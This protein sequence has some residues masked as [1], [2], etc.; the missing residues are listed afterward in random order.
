M[1][2]MDDT[3]HFLITY[4]HDARRQISME[5]FLDDE[6][7]VKAYG[8]RE[9]EFEDN[10]RIEVVLLGAD[11]EDAI[12]VTHANYFED[13]LALR[14]RDVMRTDVARVTDSAVLEDALAIMREKGYDQVPV[15]HSEDGTLVGVISARW[16]VEDD[17]STGPSAARKS[18]VRDVMRPTLKLP[19]GMV[20]LNGDDLVDDDDL[21]DYYRVHDFILIV[22]A[23]DKI[24]GIAQQWD[25]KHSVGI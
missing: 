17:I 12:R 21:E 6:M 16:L 24:K 2:A 19:D 3:I 11:S 5:R 1:T 20:R 10:R 4:D 15:E 25:V 22:D 14:I 23:E 13:T 18:I 7:A 8:E 9:R